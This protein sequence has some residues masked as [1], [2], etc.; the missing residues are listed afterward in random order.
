MKVHEFVFK[1]QRGATM[2]LA[3]WNGQPLLLVN[4]ASECGF[5]PQYAK[6]ETFP[7]WNIPLKHPVNVAYEAAT[8]DLG[9]F[10]LIDPFHQETYGETAINYNRDVEV[11]PVLKRIIERI[12]E[13]DSVYQSPTDM[14]VNRVG[15]AITDDAVVQAAARQELIP[16]VRRKQ[17]VLL[18]FNRYRPQ[19]Q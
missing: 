10:N 8:T 11:F 14:G 13:S 7:V 6:L 15:F 17:C 5:T 18:E 4:T 12:T 2:P 9:D 3:R 19:G 1:A 16:F